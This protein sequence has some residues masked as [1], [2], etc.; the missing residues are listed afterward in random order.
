MVERFH[1]DRS[2][3]ANEDVD[4]RVFLIT[5]RRIEVTY[6]LEDH[7]FIPSTRSFIKPRD[8]TERKRAEDFTPTMVSS[9]QAGDT[10]M[11]QSEKAFSLGSFS[12]IIGT[13]VSVQVDP[14]Q[15]PLQTQT[16]YRMLW[17]LMR[18]E[19][20]VLFQIRGSKKEVTSSIQLSHNS[21]VGP[22][23]P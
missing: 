10:Y 12:P 13:F 15:E 18:D 1:R 19:E 23:K 3:P 17:V 4:E 14:S 2:K 21:E 11:Q 7:R 20:K 6:H 8:S 5:R 22:H 9:F 16:L